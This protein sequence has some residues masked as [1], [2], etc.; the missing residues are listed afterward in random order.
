MRPLPLHNQIR[1]ERMEGSM[2]SI[3]GG[4]F[5]PTPNTGQAGSATASPN[6]GRLS[7]ASI[8]D[9]QST[10]S[11]AGSG[12]DTVGG[13]HTTIAGSGGGHDTVAGSGHDTVASGFDTVSGPQHGD[14][15]FAGGGATAGT[16]QVV[17]TQSQ[18]G[19]N[20]VLHLPDGSTITLVGVTHVHSSFLH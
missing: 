11:G 10:I 6:A 17:A 19:G 8:T 4:L 12:G 15:R 14:V 3:P 5:Q 2:A 1:N 20:T 16:E 18:V 9:P 13:A 7:L